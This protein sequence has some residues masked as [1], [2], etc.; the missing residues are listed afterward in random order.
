MKLDY[1]NNQIVLS[2]ESGVLDSNIELKD[3]TKQN[4]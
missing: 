4:A 2:G 1:T 3:L